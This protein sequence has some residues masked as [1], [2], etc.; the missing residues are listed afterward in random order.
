MLDYPCNEQDQRESPKVVN[1]SHYA[2]D[3]ALSA[4]LIGV[5]AKEELVRRS[6][7]QQI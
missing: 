1:P 5:G 3:T 6:V 7:P 2:E 4:D